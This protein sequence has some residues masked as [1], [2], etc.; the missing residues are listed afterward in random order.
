LPL[1]REVH[2]KQE[3][4]DAVGPYLDTHALRQ[5]GVERARDAEVRS[6]SLIE[7][8]EKVPGGPRSHVVGAPVADTMLRQGRQAA[9]EIAP[10]VGQHLGALQV[11]EVAEVAAHETAPQPEGVVPH[12]LEGVCL[13][14]I[15]RIGLFTPDAQEGAERPRPSQREAQVVLVDDAAP[16]R[17]HERT[18][19]TD[20]TFQAFAKVAADH[21][22]HR[23]HHQAVAAQVILRTDDVDRDTLFPEG[24]I[25]RDAG[26][27]VGL[28]LLQ[29]AA[30]VLDRPRVLPVVDDR[31]LAGNSRPDDVVETC[32]NVA[33]VG[34]VAKDTCVAGAVVRDHC[35]VQFLGSAAPGT[36]LEVHYR[37]R[38]VGNGLQRGQ[39]VHPRALQAHGGH[40][41]LGGR[42]G[43]E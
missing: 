11:Q 36:P 16:V 20:I 8:I 23:S 4:A 6:Q 43:F 3:L 39:T 1:R 37:I 29:G 42:G 40:V 41:V 34:H 5:D 32:Q 10:V 7:R 22:Q 14:R 12:R 18:T 2:D 13:P 15:E 27:G 19:R 28:A 17:V 31:H 25:V 9:V 38:P 35:A 21:V 26:I 33:H 24:G 30:S